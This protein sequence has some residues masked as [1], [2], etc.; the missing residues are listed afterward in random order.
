MDD[1]F[2]GN[3]F[4]II[5]L[6][7]IYI[8]RIFWS[9]FVFVRV[10]WEISRRIQGDLAAEDRCIIAS[11]FKC[12]C[13]LSAH[14]RSA[15]K[16]SLKWIT[17]QGINISHL[18]KRNIIFKLPFLGDMLVPW[19]VCRFPI[20]DL[21]NINLLYLLWG[22]HLIYILFNMSITLWSIL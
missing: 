15:K 8:C 7:F 1:K 5:L 16:I 6:Y 4:P 11:D 18:G 3:L 2:H 10:Q 12:E 20:E 14:K 21:Y 17:L 22:C 19:R 13:M 9:Y